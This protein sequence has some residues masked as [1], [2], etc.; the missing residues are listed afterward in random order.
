MTKV[1]EIWKPIPI[2][3]EY[4]VSNF[5]NA[6]TIDRWI[7]TTHKT[8]KF[9]KRFF[10]S[11]PTILFNNGRGYLVL[12]TQID[13]QKKNYYI[14]RLVAELFIHNPDN[15]KEVNHLDGNKSNNH[16]SNLEWV[17][18]EENRAH[19][20]RTGLVA[21]GERNGVSKLTDKQVLKIRSHKRYRGLTSK[22]AKKYNV[23][24]SSIREILLGINWRHLIQ[25]ENETR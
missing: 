16:V 12:G 9:P 18:R 19:A 17:T 11:R 22:L 3:P 6:R 21:R 5:G 15:K 2:R 4:E 7:I 13:L 20:V 10:K 24:N 23:S 8:A 1:K 14:H 25:N